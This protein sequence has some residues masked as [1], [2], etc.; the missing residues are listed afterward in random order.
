MI[1]HEL[2]IYAYEQRLHL[3]IYAATEASLEYELDLQEGG[4]LITFTGLKDK[5]FLMYSIICDLIR[6]EPKFLT[7]SMLA[8]Y[9]EFFR[10]SITNKATKPEHLSK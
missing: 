5:L 10:Q 9:K 6:E 8:G 2:L 1:L 7:E 3:D 4:L